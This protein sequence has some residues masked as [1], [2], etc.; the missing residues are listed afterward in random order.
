M[1]NFFWNKFILNQTSQDYFLK[2]KNRLLDDHKN[3]YAIFPDPKDFFRAFEVC[4]YEKTK[5]VILGQ[6]PYHTKGIA[7]GLAF[8]SK[9]IDIIPPSLR[10]IFKEIKDDVGVNNNTSNLTKWSE[11]GV[12]L[13]NT[14]L[15]VC[16]G[17]PNSHSNIGWENFTDL[18]LRKLS[19]Q[20][21][22][23]Y[24]LWGAHA[25]SKKSLI[26]NSGLILESS[27]PSP[28]SA[29]KGFLGSRQFSKANLYLSK[30][31]KTPIDWQ[32]A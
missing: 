28:L 31:K 22:L 12:L 29:H 27:H 16:E 9:N 19:K 13:L 8:S 2:I 1:D 26:G 10:N 3:G 18:A 15:S 23:V 30:L 24:M 5:I 20:N 6:D 4:P 17:I 25:R 11:Q 32:L 21:N 14:S 7:D